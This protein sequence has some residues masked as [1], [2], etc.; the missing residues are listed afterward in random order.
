M[1]LN[2]NYNYNYLGVNDIRDDKLTYIGYVVDKN[3]SK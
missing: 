2:Y 1:W 3:N